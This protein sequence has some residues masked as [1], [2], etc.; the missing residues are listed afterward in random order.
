MKNKLTRR[1]FIKAGAVGLAG[2]AAYKTL[3]FGGAC[4][5]P[6][7]LA[8]KRILVV[9][10]SLPEAD[11]SVA[12]HREKSSVTINGRILGNTQ[13][14]AMIIQEALGA[15]ADIFRIETVAAYDTTD[16]AKLIEYAQQEQNRNYRPP[17]KAKI[18]NPDQYDVIFLGYPIWWGDLP[19][20]LYSFLEQH[21]LS[22]KIIIPFGTHGGSRFSN[23]RETIAKLQ[24]DADIRSRDGLTISRDSIHNARAD[25]VNWVNKLK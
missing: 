19:T 17:L 24:A 22:G 25:I 14:M 20:P 7:N 21:D 3:P 13:Y 4:A 1:N 12:E 9:Y 16:H 8:G 11:S 15:N 23:T 6:A 2:M 18:D 5:A 10:Y